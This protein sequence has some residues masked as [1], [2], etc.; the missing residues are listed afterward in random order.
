MA[1]DGFS[2]TQNT[3]KTA[4]VTLLSMVFFAPKSPKTAFFQS[5]HQNKHSRCSSSLWHAKTQNSSRPSSNLFSPKP[6]CNSKTIGRSW[7]LLKTKKRTYSRCSSNLPK[8]PKTSPSASLLIHPCFVI[9]ID[10]QSFSFPLFP[11]SH[12]P[13][14][15]SRESLQFVL[16]KNAVVWLNLVVWCVLLFR[17]ATCV[18]VF[19]LTFAACLVLQMSLLL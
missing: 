10:S 15:R 17:L 7:L 13:F 5:L 9:S 19:S 3:K 4:G 11:T 18:L 14:P 8:R 16:E 12:A 1:C 6:Y 2:C